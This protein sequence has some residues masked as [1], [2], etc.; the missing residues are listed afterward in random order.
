VLPPVAAAAAP[1][2]ITLV[3]FEG[4]VA[5]EVEELEG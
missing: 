1:P 2:V 4:D 5:E 3:V